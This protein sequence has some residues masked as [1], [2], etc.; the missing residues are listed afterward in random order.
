[1]DEPEHH[2]FFSYARADNRAPLGKNGEG[3]V[4]AFHKTL[5]ER[6]R[7]F[8]GKELRIFFDT[9]AIDDLSDWRGRI[10][11]GLRSSRIFLAFLSPAYIRSKNCRWEWIEYLRREHTLVRGDD[12]IAPLYFVTVP[13]MPGAKTDDPEGMA[14]LEKELRADQEIAAW[15]DAIREDLRRRNLYIDTAAAGRHPRAAF[16]LRPWFGEGPDLLAEIDA[17]E[18]LERLRLDPASDEHD[19]VEFA[20]RIERLDRT[21]AKRLDRC[22][23]AS[24]A[25]GNLGRS[26]PHFVG[27][28]RE[29]IELHRAL[30]T[31]RAGLL[32]AAHGL[33]GQG[34]TAL[35]VQYAF[36]YAEFYAAGGRWLVPC[37]G[38]TTLGE[39]FLELARDPELNFEV[40][41]DAAEHPDRAVRE[42]LVSLREFTRRNQERIQEKLAAHPERHF[43]DGLPDPRPRA[44]V[45]LD[46][47]DAAAI[48]HPDQ[49]ALLPEDEWLEIVVTTR[50]NPAAFQA[51]RRQIQPIPIDSLPPS[52]AVALLREF[53][54]ERR[55]ASPA[56]EA[57][58]REIAEALG[59]YVL[60]VELVAA[61]LGEKE[62]GHTRGVTFAGFLERLRDEGLVRN[63]DEIALEERVQHRKQLTENQTS[64]ILEET[65][66]GLPEEAL[67][68]LR[69]A[70]F[71]SPDFLVMDWLREIVARE[72]PAMRDTEGERQRAI[73]DLGRA[74]LANAGDEAPSAAALLALLQNP[75]TATGLLE[76]LREGREKN[77][78]E[79]EG[80]GL[81]EMLEKIAPSPAH[82]P[83]RE[84]PFVALWRRLAGL[85]LL[86][87]AEIGEDAAAAPAPAEADRGNPVPRLARLHRVVAEHLRESLT[88]EA[89][90][91]CVERC[92][93]TV[94]ERQ[95]AFEHAWQ[96][97]PAS[98]WLLRPLE[99]NTLRLLR[100]RPGSHRLALACGVCG[101]AHRT[102]GQLA[103]AGQLLRIFEKTLRDENATATEDNETARLHSAALNELGNFFLARGQ[104]GDAE[105]A[106]EQ[107]QQSLDTRRR[108][109]EQNPNSAQAARDLSV[110]LNKLGDFFL[111]RGQAGD[112]EAALE[113]FQQCHE[114]LQRLYEQNPNSAQAARDLSVSLNK[115]GDFFLARG[116]AGDAEAALEQFQQSLDIAQR[117]YEQNPNSA[118]AAR[119]LSVS[120]FKFFHLYREQEKQTEAV[121]H[122]AHCFAILD[123]FHRAGR[124]MD[125]Q[126]RA[127]HAQLAPRFNRES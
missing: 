99:E 14:M 76:T 56:E 77:D 43:P 68:L 6:H 49:L 51:G 92:V 15:L 9:E 33:G 78:D 110:S 57:A 53:Q 118:Q 87:P 36:A 93:E 85:R 120:H 47:V 111:A 19:L 21:L 16:D 29:L 3:W 86:T 121:T 124:P 127:L 71:C 74:L 10:G 31:D 34:K 104:A 90:E 28:H 50:M 52:D 23:L 30:T 62:D 37:E 114:T 116:Q 112:A 105:A 108:L 80:G 117:L 73:A 45:I 60:T 100:W 81:F 96:I 64:F 89:R 26:Y 82:P 67:C 72:Y 42:V 44:L 63:L 97:D 20:D 17:G 106:L 27:R 4:T 61:W 119:D 79:E 46:N 107:F 103:R 25:P 58:A 24:M 2:V 38:K 84:D 41:D 70:A 102:I 22:L 69:H 11:A 98:H 115:L 5:T 32:T 55:F 109:Y 94:G 12:G 91:A 83:G 35:A 123:G 59:G 54:P 113:Q 13:D 8:T 7:R 101:Q 39:A 122:L 88:T 18:R 48:L 125:P 1:M 126:M 66:R 65:L 95:T 40:A 75:D